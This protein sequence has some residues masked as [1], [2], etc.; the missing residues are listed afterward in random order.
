MMS[1]AGIVNPALDVLAKLSRLGIGGNSFQQG[2]L[3]L[4]FLGFGLDV[5]QAGLPVFGFHAIVGGKRIGHEHA[6][7]LLPE[8][9]LRG[10]GG[11]VRIQEKACQIA[12]SGIPKPVRLAVVPPGGF[13]G[14]NHRER[15]DL[16]Q[17][18]Q[19]ERLTPAHGLTFKAIRAGGGRGC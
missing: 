6:A 9:F 12:V 1:L 17:Q 2:Q 11:A 3:L 4:E 8:Q 15:A 16:F 10:F 7:E 19:V 14:M 5:R 13:I 18:I